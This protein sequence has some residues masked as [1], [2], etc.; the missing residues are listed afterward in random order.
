MNKSTEMCS[1]NKAAD[2]VEVQSQRSRHVWIISWIHPEGMCVRTW[3]SE[4]V[5]SD[6]N[7][8]CSCSLNKLWRI[9]IMSLLD[10]PEV[11][12]RAMTCWWRVDDVLVTCWWRVDD[13][14]MTCWWRVDDVLMTCWWRVDDVLMTCW[15]RVDDVLMTFLTCDR[16]TPE[17][18]HSPNV[19]I[20]TGVHVWVCILTLVWPPTCMNWFGWSQRRRAANTTLTHDPLLRFHGRRLS[21]C[22][23]HTSSISI[24]WESCF[25]PD[26]EWKSDIQHFVLFTSS[27]WR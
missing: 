8:S 25:C 23:S 22:T 10:S 19:R 26:D 21:I 15:W 27:C 17:N 1:K 2:R 6:N 20:F 7:R 16:Q 18:V 5:A 4:S 9:I 24:H 12:L 14:L 11:S 13:V 3:M